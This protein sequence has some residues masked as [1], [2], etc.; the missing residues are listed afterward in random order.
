VLLP[1]KDGAGLVLA[2]EVLVATPAVRHLIRSRQ[3]EQISTYLQAGH[4]YGMHTLDSSLAK[5]VEQGL[6]TTD[7]ACQ[8]AQNK[9]YFKKFT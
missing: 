3:V 8:Y 4:E 9:E 1:R 7:V 5:L 2:T 6:V